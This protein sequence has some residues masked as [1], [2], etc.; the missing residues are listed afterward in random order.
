VQ[1]DISP[2]KVPEA[3]TPED[4]A[5]LKQHQLTRFPVGLAVLLHLVTFGAFSLFHFG[6][7]HDKLPQAKHDDPSS[8]KAVG[9]SFIPYFNLYWFVFQ[10]MRL[11]DRLNLQDRIRDREDGTSRG[12][13][14]TLAI[15]GMIPYINILIGI[16]LYTIGVYKLQKQ[17]NRLADERALE[18]QDPPMAL[19]PGTIPRP[20]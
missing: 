6:F 10:P 17:I 14:L 2:Y 4:K 18:P 15:L 12:L 19:P 8:A 13:M 20:R 7:Q 3:L 16:P 1:R 9:F 11:T 5:Y